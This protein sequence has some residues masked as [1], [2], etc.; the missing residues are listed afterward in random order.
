[1]GLK[2]KEE[3]SPALTQVAI[4]DMNTN[5]II[6]WDDGDTYAYDFPMEVFPSR[7]LELATHKV[8][9]EKGKETH[10]APID[11]EALRREHEKMEMELA[12]M[13]GPELNLDL[14]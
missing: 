11:F 9:F 2:H 3:F 10:R 5:Q 12:C 13:F 7:Q 6:A 1:M 8:V 14:D 4:I